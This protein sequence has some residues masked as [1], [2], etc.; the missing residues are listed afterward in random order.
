MGWLLLGVFMPV[1][2][3]QSSE[4]LVARKPFISTSIDGMVFTK[5]KNGVPLAVT[6]PAGITRRCR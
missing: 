6:M 4:E 1:A 2:F 3:A 5:D